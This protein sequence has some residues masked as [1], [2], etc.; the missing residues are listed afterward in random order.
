VRF[1][2]YPEL[3]R[4]V[5]VSWPPPTDFVGGVIVSAIVTITTALITPTNSYIPVGSG[6]TA[7]K[8][9]ADIAV[10]QFRAPREFEFTSLYF[11]TSD[12]PTAGKTFTLCFNINGVDS[13][14]IV[15]AITPGNYSAGASGSL[16]VA[17][18]DLVCLHAGFTGGA[19]SYAI[20]TASSGYRMLPA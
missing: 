17:Q 1:E 3:R 11:A 8:P 2:L 4:G 5:G 20:R 14:A 13:A 7:G 6:W 16:S 15:P 12:T 9:V 19:V 18:D 10:T